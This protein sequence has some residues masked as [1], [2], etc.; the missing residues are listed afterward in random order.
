MHFGQVSPLSTDLALYFHISSCL[1]NYRD[2]GKER[3]GTQCQQLNTSI[4]SLFINST[5]I[6]LANINHMTM[7]D[8]KREKESLEGKGK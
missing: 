7:P 4:G 1:Y 3:F 2:S 6:S 5:H 8:F